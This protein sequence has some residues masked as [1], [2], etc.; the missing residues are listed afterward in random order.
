MQGIFGYGRSMA[1]RKNAEKAR[2][3][4]LELAMSGKYEDS[5]AIEIALR[6]E[7]GPVVG[8]RSKFERQQLDD[9]CTQARSDETQ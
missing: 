4:S 8:R 1:V 3:R 7:F 6:S 9:M 2:M 5:L